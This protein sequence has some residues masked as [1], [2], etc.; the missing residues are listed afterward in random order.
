VSPDDQKPP[1]PEVAALLRA[2]GIPGQAA[3]AEGG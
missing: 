3:D 1:S 2:R